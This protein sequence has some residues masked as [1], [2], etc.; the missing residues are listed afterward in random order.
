MVREW[1][2]TLGNGTVLTRG[3]HAPSPYSYTAI[4]NDFVLLKHGAD[5]M[6]TV[7]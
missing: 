2:F 3:A 6:M 7:S 1:E 4:T 5:F